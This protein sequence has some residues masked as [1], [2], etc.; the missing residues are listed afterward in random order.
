MWSIFLR[1][2][3][4]FLLSHRRTVCIHVHPLLWT[5]YTPSDFS[6]LTETDPKQIPRD[7]LN[8]FLA[9]SPIRAQKIVPWEDPSH[10]TKRRHLRKVKQV[11]FVVLEEIAKASTKMLLQSV[12]SIVK[13]DGSVDK[14]L[15]E[16]LVECY[17]NANHW[18]VRRQIISIMA[19]K[20][21]FPILKKWIPGLT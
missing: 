18:R 7:L 14:T 1:F 15:M 4:Y 11:A 12:Q 5:T 9:A 16:S 21:S 20:V 19:D 2:A 6:L 17:N 3:S 10:R 13:S 8:S